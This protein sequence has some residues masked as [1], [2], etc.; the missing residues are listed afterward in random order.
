M[1]RQYH[2]YLHVRAPVLV[3]L[4][5][6]RVPQPKQEGNNS[7]RAKSLTPWYRPYFSVMELSVL[8]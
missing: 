6:A 1:R 3:V 7:A 4:L 5:A 8:G 2:Q